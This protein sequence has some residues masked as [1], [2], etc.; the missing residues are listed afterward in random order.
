MSRNYYSIL[1]F[2]LLLYS[3]KRKIV[4]IKMFIWLFISV[5]YI[6]FLLSRQANKTF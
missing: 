3:S 6:F 5:I 4:T 1:C 2:V